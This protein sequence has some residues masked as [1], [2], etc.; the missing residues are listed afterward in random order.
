MTWVYKCAVWMGMWR[1]CC[2]ALYRADVI[3]GYQIKGYRHTNTLHIQTDAHIAID[4]R[5]V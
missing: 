5:G 4:T 3:E 1:L 2:I